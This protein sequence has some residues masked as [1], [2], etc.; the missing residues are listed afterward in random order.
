MSRP[1]GPNQAVAWLAAPPSSAGIAGQA[2]LIGDQVALTCAH[3]VRDHLGLGVRSPSARPTQKLCLNFGGLRRP[4]S[5]RVAECGWFPEDTGV[6]LEDI[7]VLILDEQLDEIRH[8]N[9]AA[10]DPPDQQYCY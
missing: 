7:A 4:V 2:F 8:P 9:L 3:V 10:V 1:L 5:A 6:E